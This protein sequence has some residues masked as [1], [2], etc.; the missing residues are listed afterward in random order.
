MRPSC[1]SR[2]GAVLSYLSCRYR[3]WCNVAGML[4]NASTTESSETATNVA[5]NA[6]AAALLALAGSYASSTSWAS[7]SVSHPSSALPLEERAPQVQPGLT[8][9][10]AA[11]QLGRFSVADAVE[12]V[13]PSVV[14]IRRTS[15]KAVVSQP[16]SRFFGSLPLPFPESTP[17]LD[18]TQ[19]SGGSGFIVAA[20]GNIYKILTNSHVVQDLRCQCEHC[21]K[22][23]AEE[24]NISEIDL[25]VTL[26]SGETFKGTVSAADPT[27]DLAVVCIESDRPLPIA[28]L[29]DSDALR[30]GEFVVA[31]GSPLQVLSNS[32]SFGIISSVRRDLAPATGSST[33]GLTF[34][35]VDCAVN[36]GS[37]G[38]PLCDLDGKVLGVCAMKIGGISSSNILGQDEAIAVEGISFAIPISYA[39]KVMAEFQQYGQVRRSYIGLA[40]V[41]VN[42]DVMDD[43]RDDK[44]FA[45]LPEWLRTASQHEMSGLLIHKVDKNS[46]GEKASLKKGDVILSADGHPTRTTT[47]FMSAV[48]FKLDGAKVHLRVRR[49]SSGLVEDVFTSPSVAGDGSRAG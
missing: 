36:P 22:L 44:E 2:H 24:E 11:A 15:R 10:A 25:E 45:Y 17:E 39:R 1:I 32:C 41:A 19:V 9:Y 12:R 33:G 27:S 14:N 37:S 20:E 3:A 4:G 23:Q 6:S 5:I 40:L 42:A 34:L 31:V 16:P 29:G 30:P 8:K 18:A 43:M 13:A 35:Q 21:V 7:S 28:E 26:T 48:A 46:P 49:A 47:D 38:G